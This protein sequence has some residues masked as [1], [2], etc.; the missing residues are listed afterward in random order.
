MARL[1]RTRVE[2]STHTTRSHRR[3]TD[4]AGTTTYEY[5]SANRLT[6]VDGVTYTWDAR[7]NLVSDG[8]FTYTYNGAGRMV[9]AEGVTSTLVY[10]YNAQGLLNKTQD[11]RGNA[12][13]FAWDW[14]SGLPEMLTDGASV[15]LVGH[16]TLGRW[17]GATWAYHLPD[18]LGSVRQVADGVGAVVS[19]REW[20]PYG[21]ELALS[22]VEGVGGAQAGL[23]YTG[24]W[25]DADVGLVYLRARWLN[26]T[27]GGFTQRD[28]W[29]GNTTKPQ[30][31]FQGYVYVVNN[32][33]NFTDPS[34]RRICWDPECRWTVHPVT[35]NLVARDGIH[36]LSESPDQIVAFWEGQSGPMDCAPTSLAMALSILQYRHYGID[37]RGVFAPS[38]R[39]GMQAMCNSWAPPEVG[40]FW[41][42]I[43]G[44]G[45]GPWAI[46][47]Y[48]RKTIWTVDH[49]WGNTKRDLASAI[50]AD[51]V[52]LVSYGKM[53]YTAI[54][55]FPIYPGVSS[56]PCG[57]PVK[58]P[59]RIEWAHVMLLYAYDAV[60][61][62]FGFLD[63][64]MR[65]PSQIHWIPERDFL[66]K[67]DQMY[68]QMWVIGP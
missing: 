9:G 11:A 8:T 41:C 34:G 30:T 68:S 58:M 66:S 40:W 42:Y 6:S 62:E 13:T 57:P 39:R 45:A 53:E 56:I 25:F 19:A 2:H 29:E 54:A 65:Y 23:G 4:T 51:Q 44:K 16:D 47:E 15:H 10:T 36:A 35:G 43:P 52:T 59:I 24:E 49:T 64:D 48:V 18:A 55:S 37:N 5:D 3:M 31:L 50:D 60:L 28:S 38:V 21:V 26:P 46:D 20:S 1:R 7:S 14:A 63:P 17:D 12:T 22:G 33:I 61:S 32:P 67:W 27:T